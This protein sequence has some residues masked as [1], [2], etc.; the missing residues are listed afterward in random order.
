MNISILTPDGLKKITGGERMV[1][2]KLFMQC[3]NVVKK[4]NPENRFSEEIIIGFV[5]E[6]RGVETFF[7]YPKLHHKKA[8]A[9]LFFKYCRPFGASNLL[10]F[11]SEMLDQL[12]D[13]AS[14]V[15]DE[16]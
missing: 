9:Q 5:F 6:K 11:P 3:C 10:V 7:S 8:V 12:L 2:F 4:Q 13:I 1:I 15:A 14:G 16:R